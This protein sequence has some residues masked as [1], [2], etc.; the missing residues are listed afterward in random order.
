MADDPPWH[1]GDLETTLH[2]LLM[3]TE[4]RCVFGIVEAPEAAWPLL[5]A[6]LSALAAEEG[7]SPEQVEVVEFDG[8]ETSQDRARSLNQTRPS[9]LANL[10]LLAFLAP[11]AERMR[12][13]LSCTPDL[14]TSHDFQ[15]T[16]RATP[17][18]RPWEDVAAQIAA[19][20]T[21]QHQSIDLVGLLPHDTDHHA[22]PLADLYLPLVDF[23]A[24]RHMPRWLRR[25][26]DLFG[27]TLTAAPPEAPLPPPPRAWLVLGNPGTGKTT[28]LRYLA[29]AAALGES[30]TTLPH[31]RTAV[32]LSL[33]EWAELGARDRV[34]DL[35]TFLCN[36]LEGHGVVGGQELLKHLDE[37]ALLLDGL[38][39]VRSPAFRR[40]VLEE[41]RQLLAQGLACVVMTARPFVLDVPGLA[42]WLTEM[43]VV[44]TR[45]PSQDE[46]ARFVDT[47][48]RARRRPAQALTALTTQLLQHPTLL[49]LAST[50]LVLAFLCVLDEIS[51]RLPEH[52][53]EIYFRLSELL[54]ERWR[55]ARDQAGASSGPRP[56]RGDVLRVLG[57]LA[58]WLL[59]RGGAPVPDAE[60]L[61]TLARI[62]LGRDETPAIA[63]ERA[64]RLLDI[65]KADTA[66][67]QRSPDGRWSFVHLSLVEFFAAVETSRDDARWNALLADP[68]SPEQREVLL[69]LA[70]YL[71]MIEGRVQRLHAL[72]DAV[73]RHSRRRGVYPASYPLLLID[74]VRDLSPHLSTS[75][76][77]ALLD[78]IF[79][80]VLTNHFGGINE[81][82]QIQYAVVDLM[83]FAAVSDL[84]EPMQATARRWLAPPRREIRWERV[85]LNANIM[86]YWK[87]GPEQKPAMA[88]V[89]LSAAERE[90]TLDLT[91]KT[92][93]AESL[94]AA[95]SAGV[96]LDA[97]PAL[98]LDLD[99]EMTAELQGIIDKTAAESHARKHEKLLGY[100]ERFFRGRAKRL[101][102]TDTS[103]PH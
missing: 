56:S 13:L 58:F 72:C 34:I 55:V 80:F 87:V 59:D 90:G 19:L 9:V 37:T 79:E 78:R 52:R 50:P 94:E 68:F 32:L 65:L 99:V 18:E 62:E 5:R 39:E 20:M 85:T 10:R 53:V 14:N 101:P 63:T 61:Q 76:Q 30:P 44:H 91:A 92:L 43:E 21:R 16:V 70:G 17:Q 38:D 26:L 67:L 49:S 28:A 48:G 100:V 31:H 88:I 27:D 74:L 86:A 103:N 89:R 2:R 75:H 24:E 82:N 47:F 73:L 81:L 12:L 40:H 4:H 57:P 29:R 42:P 84:R 36:W 6:R 1:L 93:L 96:L 15:L 54:V 8:S 95:G 102:P 51:G 11:D 71:A 7:A 64:R 97:L 60:L 41:V 46:I 69:L 98:L 77:R 35:P 3:L 45:S 25:E 33:T 22:I 23:G 66:L 83:R